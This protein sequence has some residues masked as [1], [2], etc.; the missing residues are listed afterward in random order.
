MSES[1]FPQFP[2]APR[3][4]VQ[5]PG[6]DEPSGVKVRLIG[7]P[8]D[9]RSPS[10]PVRVRGEIVQAGPGG[11]LRIRTPHGDIE[12]RVPEGQQ[13]RRLERG[14]IVELEITRGR[15]EPNA[16]E[17]A[18]DRA[19]LRSL[20]PVSPEV[21]APEPAAPPP[22]RDAATPVS[23]ELRGGR[24]SGQPERAVSER[25]T[26]SGLAQKSQQGHT[27]L[28]P[29]GAS[30]RFY[31]VSPR[32]LA[33]LKAEGLAGVNLISAVINTIP[34]FPAAARPAAV[35]PASLNA[36]PPLPDLS[37][38]VT[39]FPAPPSLSFLP[40]ALPP[41]TPAQAGVFPSS[42]APENTGSG[43]IKI[44]NITL[45]LTFWRAAALGQGDAIGTALALPQSGGISGI[46]AFDGRIEHFSL[47]EPRIVPPGHKDGA[48]FMLQNKGQTAFLGGGQAGAMSGVITGV[49]ADSLPLVTFWM[50]QAETAQTFALQFPVDVQG[51]AP[52]TRISI[53]PQGTAFPPASMQGAVPFTLPALLAPAPWPVLE[54]IYQ[55][56]AQSAPQAARAFASV[57]PAPAAPATM[58]AAALFFIAALRAGD[59]QGWA[60]DKTLE[61]LR[62]T[63]RSGLIDRLTQE[64]RALQGLAG[65]EPASAQEW[66]SLPLPL[67]W[68]GAIHRIAL[69]YRQERQ[70]GEPGK[71]GGSKTRFI[72]DLELDHMGKVQI[73]GLFHAAR[74]DVI[75]RTEEIF[76]QA[77]QAQMRRLYADAL[78]QTRITGELS[79]QTPQ[80]GQWVTVSVPQD[81]FGAEA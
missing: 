27:S 34:D 50:P 65:R 61:A 5:V 80:P 45:P 72:F 10:A 19:V 76:S 15:A 79:F 6:R 41:F 54:D 56:L 11:A 2:S 60:G 81:R 39:H 51:I 26:F 47:P 55:A 75:L 22:V 35:L 52:G 40:V 78:K 14:E 66:R 30:V 17:P 13:G 7:V 42:A 4:A 36:L 8:H 24:G 74:L 32:A 62:R 58:G 46:G 70:E 18:P 59:I 43:G 48:L 67:F 31:P 64:G 16:P 53:M 77:A 28:P 49:T 23:V 63:G 33:A 71:A 38:L 68:E 3:S 20:R 12:A 44:Q 9:L 73:D 25:A 69:H 37:G 21:K 1:G 29:V 57:L